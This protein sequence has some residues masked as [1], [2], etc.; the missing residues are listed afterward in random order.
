MLNVNQKAL[1]GLCI[2]S[3][4]CTM[5]STSYCV[6]VYMIPMNNWRTMMPFYQHSTELTITDAILYGDIKCLNAGFKLCYDV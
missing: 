1:Q 6:I 5:H 3:T 2:M 4:F